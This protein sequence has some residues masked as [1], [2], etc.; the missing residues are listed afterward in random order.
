MKALKMILEASYIVN[1][2]SKQFHFHNGELEK[3]FRV[4]ASEQ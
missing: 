1:F 4:L 2:A 3:L